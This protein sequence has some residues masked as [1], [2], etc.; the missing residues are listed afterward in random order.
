MQGLSA[1][2]TLLCLGVDARIGLT[3]SSLPQEIIERMQF[4]DDLIALVIAPASSQPP[5]SPWP[6]NDHQPASS[7]PSD[8]LPLSQPPASPELPSLHLL[9]SPHL[10]TDEVAAV[11]HKKEIK[12]RRIEA[13]VGQISQAERM[14]KRSR[15]LCKPG[16]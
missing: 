3:S 2:L 1:P 9:D 8:D 6:S 10:V 7:E 14:V 12:K 4:E 16:I 11:E 5:A 15:I 13:S